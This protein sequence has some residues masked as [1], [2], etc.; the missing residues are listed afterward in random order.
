MRKKIYV[1]CA[2]FDVCTMRKIKCMPC[3]MRK[4]IA[5]CT[6]IC[7]PKLSLSNITCSFYTTHIDI[8]PL[9]LCTLGW[10]THRAKYSSKS[11]PTNNL[12]KFNIIFY[13][14]LSEKNKY[15]C[16]NRLSTYWATLHVYIIIFTDRKKCKSG[17]QIKSKPYMH[18]SY[19]AFI[20]I[21]NWKSTTNVYTAKQLSFSLL[22]KFFLPICYIQDTRFINRGMQ[23]IHYIYCLGRVGMEFT[24]L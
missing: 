20:L 13:W 14:M 24:I 15:K 1:Q 7:I 19:K 21:N 6:L 23:C 9:R 11:M 22:F 8:C 16:I 17:N 5:M 2:K 18:A 12:T 3:T 4:I 10:Q